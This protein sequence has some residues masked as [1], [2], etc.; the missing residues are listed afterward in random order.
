MAR[1]KKQYDCDMCG[2]E[3]Y[4]GELYSREAI[5]SRGTV[6]VTRKHNICPPDRDREEIEKELE[7]EDEEEAKEEVPIAA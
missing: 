6:I 1:A 7:R 4:P 3:I 2:L 5:A